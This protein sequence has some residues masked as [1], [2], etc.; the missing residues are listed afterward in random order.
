[1]RNHQQ[2]TGPG[3][4]QILHRRQHIGIQVVGRLVQNQHIRLVQENE[5]ELQSSLLPTRQI[6]HRSRKLRARKT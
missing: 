4:E 6:F 5:H 3:I 1:M 2:G